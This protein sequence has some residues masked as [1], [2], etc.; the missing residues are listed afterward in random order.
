[1]RK[2][3][4]WRKKLVSLMETVLEESHEHWQRLRQ[5][6]PTTHADWTSEGPKADDCA[7]CGRPTDPLCRRCPITLAAFARCS[8]ENTIWAK[9]YYAWDAI[10]ERLAEGKRPTREQLG[11][12]HRAADRMIALLAS[13]LRE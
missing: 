1:M 7:L 10:A 12:W 3:K 5:R 13:L 6:E 11:N 2:P 8:S 4:N 9:A